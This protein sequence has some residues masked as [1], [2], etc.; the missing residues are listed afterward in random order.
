[1]RDALKLGLVLMVICAVSG[2]L[3][4]YVHGVTSEIIDE[5]KAQEVADAMRVVLPSA[6]SFEKLSDDELASIK[7]TRSSLTL[8]RYTRELTTAALLE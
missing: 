1:M 2:G 3:L 6:E 4:A 8:T 7:L 5:R